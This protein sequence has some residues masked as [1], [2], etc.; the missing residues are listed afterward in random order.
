MEDKELDLT[1]VN[2]ID[3]ECNVDEDDDGFGGFVKAK[4]K[5]FVNNKISSTDSQINYTPNK[6]D[7]QPIGAA[8]DDREIST[9]TG[10]V[11]D[12]GETEYDINPKDIEIVSKPITAQLNDENGININQPLHLE[13]FSGYNSIDM[14]CSVGEDDDFGGFTEEK[15]SHSGDFLDFG[16]DDD[17]ERQL[18][19]E[20]IVKESKKQADNQISQGNVEDDYYDKLKKKHAATNKKGAYNTHFHFSYDPKQE[21]DDFNHDNTPLGPIPN[22]S[23]VAEVGAGDSNM[24]VAAQGMGMAE[25]YRKLFED[26]LLITG[27]E[28][29]D[30]GNGEY[31]LKDMYND[32][33]E[34]VCKTINDVEDFLNP[35]VQDC[36]II[37]L[38]IETGEQ[39]KTC[40]DWVNWYT[41]EMEKKYPQCKQ[42]IS[43]CDLC[44]NHLHECKLF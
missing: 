38:Q 4:P 28:L 32:K 3:M 6:N 11:L 14:E 15:I 36:F 24:T 39:F 18:V 19:S 41:P 22:A 8:N 40:K 35:Y 1:N 9:K 26:L 16:D 31:K 29:N 30:C 5:T 43:Y 37:P 27:F 17:I 12:F 23:N 33:S 7:P 2:E 34:K 42:D 20:E 44:A 25:G 13:D 10:I 21:M